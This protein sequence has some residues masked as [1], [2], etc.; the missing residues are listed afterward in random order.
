MVNI[1]VFFCSKKVSF[2]QIRLSSLIQFEFSDQIRPR[3]GP[4]K[5]RK[6]FA[7]LQDGLIGLNTKELTPA[8]GTIVC[9]GTP[10]GAVDSLRL[11]VLLFKSLVLKNKRG[12]C[13]LKT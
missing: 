10:V 9:L 12:V 7:A 8:H 5:K 4:Y 6:Y 1:L 11:T 3:N 2:K 13:L